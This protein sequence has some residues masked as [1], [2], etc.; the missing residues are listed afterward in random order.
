MKQLDVVLRK[1]LI[2]FF[3]YYLMNKRG[4]LAKEKAKKLWQFSGAT[5]MLSQEVQE[6]LSIVESIAWPEIW[7]EITDKTGM[8]KIAD[9]DIKDVVAKLS[10]Q[11]KNATRKPR[12]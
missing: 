7:E 4:D 5:P 9:K 2:D 8:K 11:M 3:N 1:E 10:K 6:G 12:P